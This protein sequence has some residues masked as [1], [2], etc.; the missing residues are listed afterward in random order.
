MTPKRKEVF[1]RYGAPGVVI[2]GKDLIEKKK[3]FTL[4]VFT[5]FC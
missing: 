1:E 3:N 2:D 4:Q 5:V